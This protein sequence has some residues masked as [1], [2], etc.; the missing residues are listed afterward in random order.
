MRVT[1]AALTEAAE[2]GSAVD[3]GVDVVNSGTII[4]AV[5]ARL[6]GLEDAVVRAEPSLLPLFPDASGRITLHVDLPVSQPAG[7][8]PVTVEISS[9]STGSLHHVDAEV[10][11]VPRPSVSL[12]RTPRVVRTR[13]VGRFVLELENTG[14]VALDCVLDS[15]PNDTG[16]VVRI[17]PDRVRVEPGETCP[18]IAAVRGPRMITGAE[19]DRAADVVL[20]ARQVVA[21]GDADDADSTVE[22]IEQTVL[23]L[24]QQPKVSRGALTALILAGIVGMWA[25]VFLL[26]LNQVFAGD[27]VTKAAPASFFSGTD[28]T[29]QISPAAASTPTDSLPKNGLMPAGVGGEI[30]GVVTAR[31]DGKPVGRIL[32]EAYRDGPDGRQLFS[33]AATQADGSYSLTGLFP[34]G[35]RLKF[36]ADG[37]RTTWFP[38]SS[39]AAGSQEVTAVAQGRVEGVDAE[40]TGLPA[41]IAGSVDP[42]DS[43]TPVP[44]QVVARLLSNDGELVSAARATTNAA[45]GYQLKGLEAPGSYQISFEAPGYQTTTIVQKVSGGESRLQPSVVL[46][47][48]VGQING[49][50]KQRGGGPVGG[51]TVSTTVGGEPVAVITPTTGAVGAYS[52]AN[53][54]TPGTYVVTFSG[55]G[56]GTS[57]TIIDLGPGE[58]R[59]SLD[60][61]LSAGTGSVSGSVT[62][63]GGQPLGGVTVTVGGATS[64]TGTD[65]TTTAPS[66]TTLTAGQVGYY[67]LNDLSAPGSYTLT[68]S[69]DGFESETVPVTLAES[70]P[71]QV[72]DVRLGDRLGSLT[73][74]VVGKSGRLLVGA[75]VTVSNGT[76]TYTVQSSAEGAALPQGGYLVSGLTPGS[77]SVTATYADLTQRTALVEVE[78]G[79]TARW[80]FRL[81]SGVG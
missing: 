29:G 21:A 71:A 26:G 73:G 68:F 46:S 72:V 61:T 48:G 3:I 32:V 49:T 6:I 52:L 33:S 38:A 2:P 64:T 81:L 35:Y 19:I 62:G 20:T 74:R 80:S 66:T 17:T 10:E 40:V 37:Y 44:T 59:R 63:P 30:E 70:G 11:V 16:A 1:T 42:G 65:G 67:G 57:S 78:P 31:S 53:L 12:R 45:G 9:Q 5:T 69:L 28:L 79:K 75:T 36:S 24:K 58:S 7:V 8:H 39:S 50:V 18:V 27:P 77:Y 34:T 41:S 76:D 25:A 60:Q 54:P 51:I 56:Y 22:I 4:D 55:P 43:V 14:N 13:R 23:Q 47:A 15:P